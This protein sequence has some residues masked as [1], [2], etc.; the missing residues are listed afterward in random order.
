MLLE[1]KIAWYSRAITRRD[2]GRTESRVDMS[3]SSVLSGFERFD[4]RQEPPKMTVSQNGVTFDKMVA[5]QLGNPQ[6]VYFL[7]DDSLKRVAIQ[8]CDPDD[9]QGV[10]FWDVDDES[11]EK[12]RWHYKVLVQK[13]EQLGGFDLANHDYVMSGYL[14]FEENAMFFDLNTAEAVEPKHK[15]K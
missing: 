8:G 5:E 1:D 14:L 6:R 12:I 15:K 4:I 11:R 9:P 2:G 10:D 7:T 13:L 3:S